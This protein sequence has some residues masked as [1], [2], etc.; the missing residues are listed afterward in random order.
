MSFAITLDR[1]E[2]GPSFELVLR[3][4]LSQE[5][6]ARRAQEEDGLRA[7]QFEALVSIGKAPRSLLQDR[8]KAVEAARAAA[9]YY[10]KREAEANAAE[11]LS[12]HSDPAIA[13]AGA[14]AY[15]AAEMHRLS[16]L[17][18]AKAREV[19]ADAV[20]AKAVA[21]VPSSWQ[22]H[23]GN[24]YDAFIEASVH[25]LV[26][27]VSTLERLG[28]KAVRVQLGGHVE[29]NPQDIGFL[30]VHAWPVA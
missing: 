14:A 17:T 21:A 26:A 5:D 10:S 2:T 30:S 16:A 23:V 12:K 8:D 1:I 7:I 9:D 13:A 11:S 24:T 29:S 18:E 22:A 19:E 15:V 27:L 20:Q 4:L 28:A 3:N 6:A 25:A